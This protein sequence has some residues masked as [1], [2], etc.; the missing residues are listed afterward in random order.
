MKSI[1]KRWEKQHA[2]EEEIEYTYQVNKV[3]HPPSPKD[4]TV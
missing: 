4:H 2:T 3:P 1:K